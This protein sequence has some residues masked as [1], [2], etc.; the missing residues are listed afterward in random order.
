M[1]R[2][3][4]G[5]RFK[6]GRYHRVLT[7]VRAFG[8]WGLQ[9]GLRRSLR[10]PSQKRAWSLVKKV[11]LR[12]HEKNIVLTALFIVITL[13]VRSTTPLVTM[14]YWSTRWWFHRHVANLA[15]IILLLIQHSWLD[16]NETCIF[17]CLRTESRHDEVGGQPCPIASSAAMY[18]AR[19]D[20][21]FLLYRRLSRKQK[22]MG[23]FVTL[24]ED[25]HCQ[26]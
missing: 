18:G 4:H 14:T 11:G 26:F 13:F 5:C 9:F 21:F 16:R 23:V 25:C 2:V 8:R 6:S 7:W 15:P 20:W 12:S 24:G 3:R 22:M 1:C 19:G 10:F 17:A